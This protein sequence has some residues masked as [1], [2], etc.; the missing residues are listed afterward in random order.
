MRRK[1]NRCIMDDVLALPLTSHDAININNTR[2]YLRVSTLAEITS[3]DGLSLRPELLRQ[4]TVTFPQQAVFYSPPQSTL[5]WPHSTTPRTSDWR[6]WAKTIRRLYITDNKFKL[7]TPLRNWRPGFKIR[8]QWT[9]KICPQTFQL[10]HFISNQWH[11]YTPMA[12]KHK[13]AYYDH[14]MVTTPVDP[15][16]LVLVTPIISHD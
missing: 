5:Q 14:Y 16:T 11:V 2:L 1:G 13:Y 15:C 3:H 7:L 12:I 8:F 9:W 6:L 4:P 10:Y